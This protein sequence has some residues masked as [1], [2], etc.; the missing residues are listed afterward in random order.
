MFPFT[1]F[2]RCP[3]VAP[4]VVRRLAMIL[5]G[6]AAVVAQRFLRQPRLVGLTVPL[7]GWLR[8]SAQRFEAAV[9]RPRVVRAVVTG[10][11]TE[12]PEAPEVPE[13]PEVLPR[14]VRVAPARVRLPAGKA[15]LVRALG[16]EVA[17]YGSQL[18]ALLG[19]AEMQKL[20]A[21]VPSVGRIL[22][23]LCR[24]LGVEALEPVRAV[25]AVVRQARVP[26][27]RVM[28][29]KPWSPGPIRA[30]WQVGQKR[31]SWDRG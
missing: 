15:W 26:R 6:I 19:E 22:R 14:T 17:G 7:W 18:A 30:P 25:V 10:S 3:D 1:A 4:E 5:A 28:R 12:A 23:P 24:M 8:R 11:V 9:A 2:L 13:V 21:E 20:L 29:E 27:P 31:A 16:W